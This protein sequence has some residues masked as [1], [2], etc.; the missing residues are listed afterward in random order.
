MKKPKPKAGRVLESIEIGTGT[1]KPKVRMT[2]ASAIRLMLENDILS[3]KL[4]PGSPIDEK[5]LASRFGVSRTPIREAM[6]QRRQSELIEKQ[7][8]RDA[9]VAKQDLPCLG[10]V[11]K[12]THPQA[13]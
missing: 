12:F 10:P 8:C 7:A 6:L 2:H 9:I 4:R 5:G 13:D 1:S 11:D 3:G